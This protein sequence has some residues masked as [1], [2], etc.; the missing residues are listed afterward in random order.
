MRR[1]LPEYAYIQLKNRI[2]SFELS[3]LHIHICMCILIQKFK[4]AV[5]QAEHINNETRNQ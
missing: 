5:S 4:S 2:I 3:Y 1:I